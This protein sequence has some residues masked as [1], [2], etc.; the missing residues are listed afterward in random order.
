DSSIWKLL[1]SDGWSARGMLKQLFTL[2]FHGRHT[3]VRFS[4]P[5]SLRQIADEDLDQ[6]LT[7]RKTGR[8]LRAHFRRQR[9]MAIGPDLSHRRTQ[10]TELIDAPKVRAAVELQAQA[11]GG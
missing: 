9:E 2:L 3:M 10:L 5:L 6:A 8:I 11:D 4:A 1:F 7:L